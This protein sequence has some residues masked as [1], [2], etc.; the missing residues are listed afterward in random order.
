M[1]KYYFWSLVATLA[2]TVIIGISLFFVNPN[3][4]ALFTIL[5]GIEYNLILLLFANL[6]LF[7]YH[8][9]TEKNN[10]KNKFL[11]TLNTIG[12]LY[13]IGI[14]SKKHATSTSIPGFN[15]VL[16]LFDKVS[17]ELQ[18]L[19]IGIIKNKIPDYFKIKSEN[20]KVIKKIKSINKKHPVVQ[21]PTEKLNLY[22]D[23]IVFIADDSDLSNYMAKVVDLQDVAIIKLNE[24]SE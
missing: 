8:R 7:F 22:K 11:A 24:D 19:S 17:R 12:E 4:A 3:D 15:K 18:H 16:E 21:T 9:T 6:T 13:Q 2:L 14:Y 5:T 1:K 10:L 20:E 23:I